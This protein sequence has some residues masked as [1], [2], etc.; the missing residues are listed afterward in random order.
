MESSTVSI[1]SRSSAEMLTPYS[2]SSSITNS[3]SSSESAPRSS[4]RKLSSL[5]LAPS[6][7]RNHHSK[8]PQ[9]GQTASPACN[10][11]STLAY[12]PHTGHRCGKPSGVRDEIVIRTQALSAFQPRMGRH[13]IARGVSPWIKQTRQPKAPEGRHCHPHRDTRLQNVPQVSSSASHAF[14]SS[15]CPSV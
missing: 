11:G 7:S 12:F 1:F 6:R 15:A 10:D 4:V 13:S 5:T 3:T 9:L 8:C 2:S 14:S